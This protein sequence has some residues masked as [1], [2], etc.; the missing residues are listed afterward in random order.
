L[1][2]PG[3]LV[4]YRN[5]VPH[6]GV[7]PGHGHPSQNRTHSPYR[8]VVNQPISV[9]LNPIYS[10]LLLPSMLAPKIRF[11]ISGDVCVRACVYVYVHHKHEL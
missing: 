10:S 8:Q 4:T 1:S 11:T 6:P 5:K 7:E 2:R 3:W 9:D